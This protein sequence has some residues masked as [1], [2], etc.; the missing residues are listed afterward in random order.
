MSISFLP[1]R[2]EKRT[3]SPSPAWFLSRGAR[4]PGGGSAFKR[5]HLS[6]DS[7]AWLLDEPVL[8]ADA[9]L[10]VLVAQL[11]DGAVLIELLQRLGDLLGDRVVALQ[12]ADRVVLVGQRLVEL[13][14]HA[15]VRGH[16]VLGDGEVARHGVNL[17]GLQHDE[18]VVVVRDGVERGEGGG[19]VSLVALEHVKR[20][21]V[22]LGDD[23]L[24]RQ[25]LQGVDVAV[26]GGHDDLAVQHVR[27]G[28]RVV[29]LAAFHGEAVPD[30][31]DGAGLDERVLG[32]PVDG[33]ELQVPAVLFADG[34]G[35]IEVEAGALAVIAHEA[36]RRVGLVEADD[37]VG[38]VGG[39][40][41]GLRGGSGGRGLLGG[42]AFLGR[43]LGGRAAAAGQQHGRQAQHAR[44]ANDREK[45][46]L[47]VP[48][49]GRRTRPLRPAGFHAA[50]FA[51]S[52]LS[53][54]YY[55]TELK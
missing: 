50:R 22:N 41:R 42:G 23:G 34:L 8:V 10:G 44:H 36:V 46:L 28:E 35:K 17:A 31:G 32:I 12:E 51:R 4:A 45:L 29:V 19:E 21:G 39:V 38:D 54:L 37:E 53:A 13:L 48:S 27:V 24:A 49:C 6:R 55:F 33:L 15:L 3:R 2:T 47:H 20:R 26:S 7:R 14:V 40:V 1:Y 25:I 11:L 52:A 5:G 9:V 43:R 30:T 16:L 18:R